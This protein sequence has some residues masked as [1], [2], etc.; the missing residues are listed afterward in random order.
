[1]INLKER[2]MP[3]SINVNL[4]NINEPNKLSKRLDTVPVGLENITSCDK[5][6]VSFCENIFTSTTVLNS[7]GLDYTKAIDFED[8]L[9][10]MA[11]F[12]KENVQNLVDKL[13]IS[14]TKGLEKEGV[15][16]RDEEIDEAVNVVERIKIMLSTYCEDYV[17]TGSIDIADLE[18]S[19]GDTSLKA[20]VVKKLNSMNM[21]V[22]QNNVNGVCESVREYEG[23]GDITDD[24]RRYLVRNNLKPTIKNVYMANHVARSGVKMI[25]EADF[26]KL[27]TQV[28]KALTTQGFEA[29]EANYNNARMILEEGLALNKENLELASEV[30]EFNSNLSTEEVIEKS[31]E[32]IIVKND[33]KEAVCSK[34]GEIKNAIGAF[35]SIKNADFNTV[36]KVVNASMELSI[37]S[38]NKANGNAAYISDNQKSYEENYSVLLKAKFS[39]SAGTLYTMDKLGVDVLNTNLE[40]LTENALNNNE[41]IGTMA[42]VK[43]AKEMP[44]VL[45]NEFTFGANNAFNLRNVCD[46]GG[47]LCARF[48]AAN[49]AYDTFGTEIRRDLGDNLNK[50][51]DASADALLKDLGY[52]ANRANVAAVRILSYSNLEV[53]KANVDSTAKAYDSVMNIIENISPKMVYSLIKNGVDILNMDINTL[54]DEV[55]KYN[56]E[57]PDFNDF[58]RFLYKLENS[59]EILETER[60]DYIGIYK[61]FSR[62]KK[63]DVVSM[64]D[65]IGADREVTLGNIF[66]AF[67]SRKH[68]GM[69]VSI[70]ENKEYSVKL[71]YQEFRGLFSNASKVDEMED[72]GYYEEVVNDTYEAQKVEAYVVRML[73]DNNIP[74]SVS[75]ILAA[76]EV[77]K[78]DFFERLKEEENL[79][80]EIDEIYENLDDKEGLEKAFEKLEKGAK[81]YYRE[82]L[83]KDDITYAKMKSAK[84]FANALGVLRDSA[85][86]E[87]QIPVEFD[88]KLVN[89]NLKMVSQKGAGIMGI[90]IKDER[91]GSISIKCK[92]SESRID[93]LVVSDNEER[94]E[95]INSRKKAIIDE[96]TIQGF[97][98]SRV[99]VASESNMLSLTDSEEFLEN[100]NTRKL[101]AAAKVFLSN[102][103]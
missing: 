27:D 2:V 7:G 12:A 31:I 28:T 72:N 81:D 49:K 45:L 90:S 94:V 102:I 23:I 14:D 17:P 59:K 37:A 74:V 82:T 97:T 85:D 66:N 39:L 93:A 73:T 63:S 8:E 22:T 91:I 46:R 13:T 11:E 40:A 43:E 87:Y 77:K 44:I 9:K 92:A 19:L 62:L 71:S 52:T 29:N 48:K 84:T 21:P 38:I 36:V 57:N 88:G 101:Y 65:V 34:D 18:N 30:L 25:N 86:R 3:M 95:L 50:A 51:V 10:S 96:L 99:N 83:D 64:G 41:V 1:V 47:E 35:E 15:D 79:Q 76:N 42:Y 5:A 32:A 58:A 80:E 98:D 54:S 61:I 100:A 60:E 33:A 75:N 103:L 68:S 26:L 89:V 6:K 53:N 69:D 55:T 20:K 70:D 24:A 16:I 67:V 78:S 56:E 4:N